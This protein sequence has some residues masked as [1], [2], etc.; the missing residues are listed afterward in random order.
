VRSAKPWETKRSLDSDDDATRLVA[1]GERAAALATLLLTVDPHAASY[2]CVRPY[3]FAQCTA[4]PLHACTRL[5]ECGVCILC[6]MAQVQPPT[7]Y[8]DR[9]GSAKL[10]LH[11]AC[12]YGAPARLVA[13]LLTAYPAGAAARDA[14]G[15]L[16]I[17]YGLLAVDRTRWCCACGA[18]LVSRDCAL[19]WAVAGGRASACR[20]EVRRL[21]LQAHPPALMIESV[22]VDAGAGHGAGHGVGHGA[23]HSALRALE[24]L[25]YFGLGDAALEIA[26]KSIAQL[27]ASGALTCAALHTVN[28]NPLHAAAAN[29]APAAALRALIAANPSLVR[30]GPQWHYEGEGQRRPRRPPTLPLHR[31]VLASGS[32][33]NGQH[34]KYDRPKM[35]DGFDEAAV[36]NVAVL[37]SAD[38]RSCTVRSGM[39]EVRPSQPNESPPHRGARSEGP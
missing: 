34:C 26:L 35:A 21:L 32:L 10:P 6:G 33:I 3:G 12:E 38:P 14:D 2:P 16:P 15:K 29:V 11:V 31:A 8:D 4:L 18:D 39:A 19:A 23:A 22:R 27:A 1:A 5:T 25:L 36:E 17:H 20:D 37:A 24:G 28:V 9:G 7:W 30:R 13:V